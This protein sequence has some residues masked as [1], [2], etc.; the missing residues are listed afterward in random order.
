MNKPTRIHRSRKKGAC[1]PL[2]ELGRKPVY[3]GRG[4][5]SNPS[6]WGNPFKYLEGTKPK[7]KPAERARV[8][9]LYE[10]WLENDPK[11]RAVAAAAK[12]ELRGLNL[13]CYCPLD[14]ACHADVL[15]RIANEKT[16]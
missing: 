2:D 1:Q 15:L 16:A 5:K 14:G 11:G 10:D 12:S 3:V 7:D 9:S 4:R 6:K 8:V 13:S